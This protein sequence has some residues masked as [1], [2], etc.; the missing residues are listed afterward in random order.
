M[1]VPSR[2]RSRARFARPNVLAEALEPRMLFNAITQENSLPGTPP[3]QWY[4]QP[5]KADLN[6]QGFATDISVDQG[7]TISFK[8]NDTASSPAYHLEM[9]RMGYYG[10]LGARLVATIE[11]SASQCLIAHQPD[12]VT[13]PATGLSD[14]GN[15]S[16][17]AT[18][19]VPLNATSGVYFANIV[20]NDGL[21]KSRI[22]FIVRDDASHSDLLVQTSD[23]TWQAYNHYGTPEHPLAGQSLYEGI[24]QPHRAFAVS[25]NRPIVEGDYTSQW[26]NS[27]FFA[28][29]PMVRFLEANGFDV[30]YFTDVDSDRYGS[31][32]RNH[33]VF[34]SV[35]HDEYWSGPQRANV[36]AARDAGVSLAFFSG[37]EVSWKTRLANSIDGSQTPDR[38]LVCYK[39]SQSL[40]A[41]DPADPPI[42]TS[43]WR[44]SHFGPPADAGRPQNG[45]TGGLYTANW[46]NNGIAKGWNA[47]INVPWTD[48][49]LRFW[50]NTA[51]ANLRPGQ[52]YATAPGY[53]GYEWDEDIDNGFR[54]A[55]LMDLS[56]TALDVGGPYGQY[57]AGGKLIGDHGWYDKAYGTHSLTLYRA[58]S[59]ALVFDAG[60]IQW[61]WALN[62][63]Q[64]GG[65][66][67]FHWYQSFETIRPVPVDRN[68]QQATVNLF[69][70]MGVQPDSL[71]TGLLAASASSD[72]TP[73]VSRISSPAAG[74]SLSGAVIV[75]GTAADRGGG[76]VAGVEVSI[77]GGATWHPASGT[78]NWSYTIVPTAPGVLTIES[79]AV[80][81][82]GNLETPS[83]RLAVVA[84]PIAVSVWNGAGALVRHGTDRAIP[85]RYPGIEL[86]LKFTSDVAG[87]VTGVRFWKVERGGGI[88]TGELWDA[89]GHVLATATFIAETSSGW[90][91]VSF[92]APVAIE[93]H[94]PYIVS[95]QTNCSTF[96]YNAG[97]LAT[98]MNNGALHALAGVYQYDLPVASRFP[99][100]YSPLLP[101]YWVDVIFTRRLAP[102]ASSFW[103]ASAVPANPTGGTD[104]SIPVRHAGVELGMRFTSDAAGLVAGVRFWKVRGDPSAHTGELWDSSGRLLAT[105][106]FSGETPSGWQQVSFSAPV[107]IKAD[108]TYVISYHTTN[109][110]FAFDAGGLANGMNNGQLHAPPS[111]S[112]VGGNGVYRFDGTASTHF[113]DVYNPAN[114]NYWVDLLFEPLV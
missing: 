92:S 25:Y 76:V 57:G 58:S 50:R 67:D 38:T 39:E 27:F 64:W 109:P 49:G 54:P 66:N 52:S 82:S 93:A 40:P 5:G 53:L 1:F 3:S 31:L 101:N 77:D 69:A 111:N 110:T 2:R 91:Q 19:A 65:G 29:Y 105:A 74:A 16:V 81:D 23:A 11:P 41:H 106:A 55:G 85:A 80:D 12:P 14:S 68:L 90:Q 100:Q 44:D 34:M 89:S 56:S 96:A 42:A 87:Y 60:T 21:G 9:Y 59:G 43:L 7:Q 36:E 47:S 17:S 62:G 4:I 73:P 98:P 113:P 104:P 6:I 61:S 86:G 15:W 22:P 20:R 46:Y 18:W 32:I 37:N 103:S 71:Q 51:I 75:S 97:G 108:T 30:S 95:Y 63:D 48:A 78:D 84:R 13:D 70:D 112:I 10:G 45:L 26:D 8:I 102:L 35:G 114:P 24:V 88:H 83:S 33:K 107:A 99:T 72:R 28:E 94:T 79:R